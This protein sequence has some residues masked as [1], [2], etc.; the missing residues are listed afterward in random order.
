MLL[1]SVPRMFDVI[2][3]DRADWQITRSRVTRCEHRNIWTA[4]CE[5]L[6]WRRLEGITSPHGRV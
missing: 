1:F 4:C 6:P 2:D 3:R 5:E